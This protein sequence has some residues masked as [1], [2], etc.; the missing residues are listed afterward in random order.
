MCEILQN[1]QQ[2][3]EHVGT[4]IARHP[5]RLLSVAWCLE[6]P[7]APVQHH[8]AWLDLITYG[9]YRGTRRACIHNSCEMLNHQ[10]INNTYAITQNSY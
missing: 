7:M 5:M 8:S 4:Y 2:N 1:Q 9:K 3:D 10:T 6:H